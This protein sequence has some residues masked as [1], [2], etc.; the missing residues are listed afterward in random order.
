MTGDGAYNL[1]A[2]RAVAELVAA[3][4]DPTVELEWWRQQCREAYEWGRAAGWRE[5]YEHGARLL[6]ATWAPVVAPLTGPTLAELEVLRWGPCGREHYG[7]PRPG[8]RIRPEP[9][10]GAA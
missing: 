1:A 8:D 9:R 7:D 10:E 4:P 6:E 5:G 2:L 3:Q